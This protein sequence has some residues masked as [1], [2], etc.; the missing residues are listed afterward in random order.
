MAGREKRSN[1]DCLGAGSLMRPQP[2][3]PTPPPTPSPST[4]LLASSS[5]V[6]FAS[7]ASFAAVMTSILFSNRAI[8]ASAA[9]IACCSPPT[10]T[11]R[12]AVSAISDGAC[13]ARILSSRARSLTLLRW[14]FDSGDI[15][16]TYFAG[17]NDASAWHRL[18]SSGSGGAG[19]GDESSRGRRAADS[20]VYLANLALI[21]SL[22]LVSAIS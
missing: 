16:A 10:S 1:L 7:A 13:S 18:V 6:T 15:G 19:A 17:W 22:L 3:Y 21:A 12:S 5:S 11:R 4:A 20:S 2:H 14:R 9:A 8:R